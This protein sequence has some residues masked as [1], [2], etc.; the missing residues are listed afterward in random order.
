MKEQLA[1]KMAGGKTSQELLRENA[2]L[3]GDLLAIAT[4]I[5]HDLRTPLGGIINT[6]ELLKEILIEKNPNDG[7]L[8]DSLFTAADELTKLITQVRVLTKATA[9]PKPKEWLKM[10][11]IVFG[12]LQRLES[13]VLKKSATVVEP[14][15]WPEV[16][17]VADWL[18]FIWCNLL[19]NALQ[20]G[21]EKPRLELSWLKTKS[22]FRFQVCDHGSGAPPEAVATL[23]QPFDS[24]HQP[25]GP[26][27][28]GLS[29]VQ[30]LVEL[31]GGTCGYTLTPNGGACFFFTLPL[32]EI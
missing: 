1:P 10:E 16:N 9:E 3:R 2:R 14:E 7:L 19:T 23:F 17:G 28:L 15:F 6:A 20:H 24:L 25:G 32:V 30:R 18:E 21:G 5:S 12:A 27:G 8:T 11:T 31:Q 13:R 4:R 22:G 29:V 26:R